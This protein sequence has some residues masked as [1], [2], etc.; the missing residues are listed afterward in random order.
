MAE[1]LVIFGFGV[2]VG[3]IARWVYI[4]AM[5]AALREWEAPRYFDLTAIPVNE[6]EKLKREGTE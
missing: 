4:S 2:I 5:R 1:R 6:L 3:T